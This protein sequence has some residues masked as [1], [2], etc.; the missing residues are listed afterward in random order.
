ML[1][2]IINLLFL[3]AVFVGIVPHWF[4]DFKAIHPKCSAIHALLLLVTSA[5]CLALNHL[6]GLQRQP[7]KQREVDH[8]ADS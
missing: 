3:L 1:N 2:R 5:V 7:D 4:I 6:V 8:E